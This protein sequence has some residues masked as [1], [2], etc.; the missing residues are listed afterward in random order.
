MNTTA[1]KAA[2]MAAL[3]NRVLWIAVLALG[4][5]FIVKYVPRY[6][7]Y[8]ADSYGPYFWPRANY[9]LP[10]VL[11]GLAAII[12]GPFQFWSRLRYRHPKVHRVTGRLYLGAVLVGGIGGMAMAVTIPEGLAY[13]TGLFFLSVAWM[14]TAGMALTAIRLRVIE[15]HK[16]WMIRSYVVTFAF[17]TFRVADDVLHYFGLAEI[18][19][20]NAMFAW[21]CWAVP[22]L[23]TEA[24][25]QCRRIL[26]AR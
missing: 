8:S 22:L 10:H 24:V 13:A 26:R 25:L 18:P 16:E 15:Q 21:G 1:L 23:F 19:D 7:A 9:L 2:G 5:Y 12:I 17:V 14:L 6:L 20:H 4:A 3:A 11:A